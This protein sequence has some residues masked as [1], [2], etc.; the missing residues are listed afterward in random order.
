MV[1]ADIL[2]RNTS[3]VPRPLLERDPVDEV[4]VAGHVKAVK[5]LVYNV[6]LYTT[7]LDSYVGNFT[8]DSIQR[9]I[10]NNKPHRPNKQL[11]IP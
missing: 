10:A 4:K 1:S 9:F 7:E 3:V 6:A 2:G 5:D 8:K 11:Q